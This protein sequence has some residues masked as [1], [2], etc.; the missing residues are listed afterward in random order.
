MIFR[1]P[2]IV[3][4]ASLLSALAAPAW[5]CGGFFCFTQPIDQSAERILY[6]THGGKITVHI[7]ISYTGNDNEFSWILPLQ[8]KGELGIGSDTVFQVLEQTTSPQFWLDWVQK[9]GC[10]GGNGCFLEDANGGPPS[11]GGKGV[12]ILGQQNVGPYETTTLSGDTAEAIV[13]WLNDNGY[14]QPKSTTPL[15]AQYV[16]EKFVFLALRLKKDKGV[17]DLAPIVITLDEPSPCL[18]L[19]LTQLAASPDMPIVAWVV[20][21]AR[22]IPKNF[23]H[24][25]INEAVIDWLQGG[26]NYKTVVSKA[27]D[28][29]SGHAFTTEYAQKLAKMDPNGT[30]PQVVTDFAN[31]F[32]NADWKPGD[33]AAAKTPSQFLQTMFQKGYPRSTQMQGLIKKYI[34]KP[35]QWDKVSDQEFYGCIQNGDTGEPCKS[36]LAAV[37]SQP[38]DAAA[39]AKDID[40]NIVKPLIDVQGHFTAGRYLTR[41]YTTVS[42]EEMNKDPIFAFNPDLPPVSPIH[43]AKAEPLCDAAKQADAGSSTASKVKLTF[44]DGHEMTVEVPAATNGCYFPGTIGFGQGD[45]ELVKAGG[46]A[47][48]KV[49]VLDEKGPP[50]DV[51]PG[52]TADMVDAHLN[53]AVAGKPSLSAEFLAQLPK[54]TW[55]PYHVGAPVPTGTDAGGTDSTS[56]GGTSTPSIGKSSSCSATTAGSGAAAILALLAG[57]TVLVFR[58]RAAV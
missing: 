40:D 49:Q 4:L 44:A 33:L 55:D 41:L 25:E 11:A 15:I 51:Q 34:P 38:F 36:Y 5:A 29:A 57:L 53:L 19:R 24:V 42:P 58:R 43:K 30:Y 27:V 17:G 21:N 13:K 54:V 56:A 52:A 46:Q 20:G 32:A 10:Y 45:A 6:I 37:A 16:K 23:L 39:F 22:A 50:L 9:D 47:A 48:K 12:E 28:Q 3:L 14:Q 35:A 26:N 7:Q 8:K 31:R 18:P 1:R 2:F